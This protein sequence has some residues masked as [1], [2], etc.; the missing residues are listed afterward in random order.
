MKICK[1]EV[2]W[3]IVMIMTAMSAYNA[4]PG[5]AE[6]SAFKLPPLQ[7]CRRVAVA[8]EIGGKTEKHEDRGDADAVVPAIDLGEQTAE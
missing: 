3:K 6:S 5:R 4:P 8:I 7:P 1:Y 2:D